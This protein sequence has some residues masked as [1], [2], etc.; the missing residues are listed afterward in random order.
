MTKSAAR[1]VDEPKSLKDDTTVK[2]NLSTLAF[3]PI[4]KLKA[5]FTFAPF[6]VKFTY[7]KIVSSSFRR[8]E[9]AF[10]ATLPDTGVNSVLS[11][12]RNVFHRFPPD[13]APRTWEGFC[14]PDAIGAKT[15]IRLF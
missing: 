5:I 12:R 2:A 6:E 9:N 7:D 8:T 10:K 3:H 11:R 15:D 14:R 1:Q 4:D 13:R